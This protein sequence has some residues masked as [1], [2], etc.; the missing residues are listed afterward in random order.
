MLGS[1][2]NLRLD[3]RLGRRWLRLRSG[4]EFRIKPFLFG[5]RIP[6]SLRNKMGIWGNSENCLG[7]Y[8]GI[9]DL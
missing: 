6:I 3:V 4:E 1:F 8:V 7:D 2:R 5:D 9:K